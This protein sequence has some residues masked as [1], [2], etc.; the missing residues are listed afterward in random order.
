MMFSIIEKNDILP[1]YLLNNNENIITENN[2]FRNLT[3]TK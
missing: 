3:V 1:L 2:T